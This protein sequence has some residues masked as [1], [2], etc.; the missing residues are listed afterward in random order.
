[1]ESFTIDALDAPESAE[2]GE[3]IDVTAAVTNPGD[4]E[5]TQDIEFRLEGDLVG[6]QEVTLDAGETE[7]VV[8]EV[9]TTDL[10]AGE[11]VHMVLSDEFGEVAFIELTEE[12]E[13]VDDEEEVVDDEEEEVVDDEDEV[14]DEEVVDEEEEEVDDYEDEEID[15]DEEVVDDG[16]EN[17]DNEE[18]LLIRLFGLL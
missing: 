9:D 2:I 18:P 1:M 8:F 3:T 16:D 4:E 14:D 17:D 7:D 11:F 15:D 6:S 5:D 10:E 12:E 13:V